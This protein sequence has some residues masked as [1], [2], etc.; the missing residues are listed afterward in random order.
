VT[1]PI[2]A[3]LD[4]AK[5]A[6]KTSVAGLKATVSDKMD[7]KV[8]FA[9]SKK[10]SKAIIDR[11]MA[12]K[13]E[14]DAELDAVPPSLGK[15]RKLIMNQLSEAR[16]KLDKSYKV[17]IDAYTAK[18]ADAEANALAAE[19]KQFQ[20]ENHMTA[21]DVRPPI[22]PQQQPAPNVAPMMFDPAILVN[23]SWKFTRRLEGKAPQSGAFQ[24]LDGCI[25]HVDAPNQVGQAVIGPA[26]QLI[27]EFQGHRKIA[28]GEAVV[29]KTAKG[30]G[31]GVLLFVGDEWTLEISRR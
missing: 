18:A 4:R 28:L 6:F 9:R 26:G 10:G 25:Y 15:D 1:D 8:S 23:S 7:R 19:R 11:L 27:L 21:N 13:D 12:E 22:M 14:F 29:W 20:A 31:R 16:V 17:A 2:G 5:K 3:Q 24:I 30:E